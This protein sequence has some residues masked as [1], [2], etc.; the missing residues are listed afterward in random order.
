MS[1]A[2]KMY[3]VYFTTVANPCF[4]IEAPNIEKAKEL[5]EEEL[6]FMDKEEKLRRIADAL[7]L[8]GTKV[9][10]VERIP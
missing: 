7:D 5:G 2:N 3:D 10:L 1:K 9:T 4:C 6:V 8:C